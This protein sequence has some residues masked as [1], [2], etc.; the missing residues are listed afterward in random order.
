MMVQTGCGNGGDK[1]VCGLNVTEGRD[2]EICEKTEFGTYENK[3]KVNK[4]FK[5]LGLSNLKDVV[6]IIQH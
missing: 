1:N 6:D 4:H 2:K 3:R 5:S